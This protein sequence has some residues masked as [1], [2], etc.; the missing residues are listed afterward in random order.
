MHCFLCCGSTHSIALC[1]RQPAGIYRGG[2]FSK[3][4]NAGWADGPRQRCRGSVQLPRKVG[5]LFELCSLRRGRRRRPRRQPTDGNSP[6]GCLSKVRCAGWAVVPL[7]RR[8][9]SVQL[10]RKAGRLQLSSGEE[11]EEDAL[12]ACQPGWDLQKKNL[13]RCS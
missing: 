12:C 3:V 7:Q 9:G 8:R 5:R 10:H 6:R 4:R 13:G 2:V 1:A 11:G